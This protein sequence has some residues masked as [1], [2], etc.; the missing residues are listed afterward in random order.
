M[1]SASEIDLFSDIFLPEPP[2]T[3]CSGL[4]H[5]GSRIP[6]INSVVSHGHVKRT[7][8]R[9]DVASLLK[10]RSGAPFIFSKYVFDLFFLASLQQVVGCGEIIDLVILCFLWGFA[11]IGG[12][13]RLEVLC[14]SPL[15][16]IAITR[17]LHSFQKDIN[18]K[19]HEAFAR[20]PLDHRRQ[21]LCAGCPHPP[22]DDALEE[23]G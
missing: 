21:R 20:S 11:R 1:S 6:S 14:G 16:G 23:H 4:T 3:D 22:V 9:D 18:N 17:L 12:Y 15:S 13:S 10:T 8:R 2:C 19:Y 7:A 5:S